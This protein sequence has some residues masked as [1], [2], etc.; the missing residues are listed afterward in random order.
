MILKFCE[1]F[2]KMWR[3]LKKYL[4]DLLE[5]GTEQIFAQLLKFSVIEVWEKFAGKI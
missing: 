3:F 4:E 1:K 5:I 2:T